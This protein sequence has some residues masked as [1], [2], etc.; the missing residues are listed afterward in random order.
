MDVPTQGGEDIQVGQLLDR[1][2]QGRTGLVV[3][4]GGQ[5]VSPFRVPPDGPAEN[6]PEEFWKRQ[7]ED[8]GLISAGI[9]PVS[10]G[11]V[12][13]SPTSLA[14]LLLQPEQGRAAGPQLV[15]GIVETEHQR[16][17][18]RQVSRDVLPAN[19]VSP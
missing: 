17:A 14:C 8:L 9:S 2:G 5:W 10:S 6:D 13:N 4:R 7:R 19:A 11:E 3:D 15:R 12:R 18:T 1:R 16:L